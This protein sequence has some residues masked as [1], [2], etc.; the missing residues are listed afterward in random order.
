MKDC[1]IAI[2]QYLT[3]NQKK[4][5]IQKIKELI[6]KKSNRLEVELIYNRP[7]YKMKML[8]TMIANRF[9]IK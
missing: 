8:K 6:N 9:R 1:M 2:K 3:L 7:K 4:K 5:K